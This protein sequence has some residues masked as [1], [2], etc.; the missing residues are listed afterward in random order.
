VM[1]HGGLATTD[2]QYAGIRPALSEGR[3]V[4]TADLQAHGHTADIDR[5]LRFEDLADDI[6][7]LL[8]YLEVPQADLLGYSLGGG[9]ATQLT[10][11][12]PELVRKLIVIS[13]PFAR[14]GWAPEI[15]G[16]MAAMNA[17]VAA[18][19][20]ATPLYEAYARV[21]PRVEDWPVLVTKVS[22][23]M[24]RDYDWSSDVRAISQ[25]TQVV[26]GDS[27]SILLEHAVEFFRLR[28]GGVPGDVAPLPTSEF[29]ILPRT[30]HS[31]VTQRTDLLLTIVPAFL[32][33]PTETPT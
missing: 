5:P 27:D 9:V 4:I 6:A 22:E 19:M 18:A 29:A 20:Q 1:L 14:S 24:S 12:R 10:I 28:G 3:Q 23:L 25:P 32:D 26:I 13:S 2:L 16:A 21:A 8:E 7:A 15:L 31:G 30:P 33:A 11:R 17:E